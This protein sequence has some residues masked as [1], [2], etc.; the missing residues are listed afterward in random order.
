MGDKRARTIDM[1]LRHRCW[2][3]RC[4]G[5]LIVECGARARVGIARG[6]DFELAIAALANN[7]SISLTRLLR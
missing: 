2:I 7:E 5:Q 3:L 6:F 4:A 1:D